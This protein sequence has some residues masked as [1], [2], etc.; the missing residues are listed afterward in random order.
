VWHASSA[1]RHGSRAQK[2][3]LRRITYNALWGCGDPRLGEWTEWTGYS[4]HLRRRLSVIE[5]RRIGEVRDIRGTPEATARMAKV[6][7]FL[8]P[9]YVEV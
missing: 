3:D 6:Q 8:P 4:Y 2:N 7:R 1:P 9:N 5:A